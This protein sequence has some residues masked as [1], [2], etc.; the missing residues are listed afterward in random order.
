[1][2]S[3]AKKS[4]KVESY[5]KDTR[6]VLHSSTKANKQVDRPQLAPVRPAWREKEVAA[7]SLPEESWP[8][9]VPR[10]EG[11]PNLGLSLHGKLGASKERVDSSKVGDKQVLADPPTC[12]PKARQEEEKENSASTIAD[13]KVSGSKEK[14]RRHYRRVRADR[15]RQAEEAGSDPAPK[16]AKMQDLRDRLNSKV[17]SGAEEHQTGGSGAVKHQTGGTGAKGHQSG[18]TGARKHQ[19]GGTGAAKHLSGGSGANKHQKVG[20]WKDVPKHQSKLE[21]HARKHVGAGSG[22]GAANVHLKSTVPSTKGHQITLTVSGKRLISPEMLP[23]GNY[24]IKDGKVMYKWGD[25]EISFPQEY[26]ADRVSHD[27]NHPTR[28]IHILGRLDQPDLLDPTQQLPKEAISH[29]RMLL[30]PQLK[31]AS[32]LTIG[33]QACG[34]TKHNRLERFHREAVLP[35][36]CLKGRQPCEDD[37]R[38]CAMEDQFQENPSHF[39]LADG[40][41]GDAYLGVPAPFLLGGVWPRLRYEPVLAKRCR[42]Q[43]VAQYLA[44]YDQDRFNRIADLHQQCPREWNPRG[45]PVICE[46]STSNEVGLVAERLYGMETI[47]RVGFTAHPASEP[48]IYLYPAM[49]KYSRKVPVFIQ[50]LRH[51]ALFDGMMGDVFRP[52]W[53]RGHGLIL[54]P[55]CL[56]TEEEDGTAHPSFWSRLNFI[57]HWE[58]QHYSSYVVSSTFSATQLHTRVYMGHLLYTL[59][60]GCRKMGE[61]SPLRLAVNLRAFTQYKIKTTITTLATLYPPSQE[62]VSLEVEEVAKVTED[63]SGVFVE[64]TTL[65][66]SSMRELLDGA[67]VN[68]NN[69]WQARDE[70]SS[71]LRTLEDM[72]GEDPAGRVCGEAATGEAAG[73]PVSSEAAPLPEDAARPGAA[74]PEEKLPEAAAGHPA[75]SEAVPMEVDTAEGPDRYLVSQE[76]VVAA[77]MDSVEE[78]DPFVL[79]KARHKKGNKKK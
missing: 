59:A 58:Q 71:V 79:V 26:S 25:D 39:Y 62:E 3:S 69:F 70:C 8:A 35:D 12:S 33:G 18:G 20:G 75:S 66:E 51:P 65:P 44:L 54:C 61:D 21:A 60:L 2:S 55:I 43:Q 42:G 5:T 63:E 76:D 74:R 16:V 11:K 30:L 50:D 4:S 24:Q 10:K 14:R 19:S 38:I 46:A 15:K 34:C 57:S 45:S 23:N 27:I 32:H 67:R 17:G 41:D 1:M 31:A 28:S 40:R 68:I 48:A 13:Q 52:F 29:P 73:L 56:F 77:L 36:T 47:P 22:A 37:L 9:A 53:E 64:T 78:E 49:D 6:P 7:H 72:M